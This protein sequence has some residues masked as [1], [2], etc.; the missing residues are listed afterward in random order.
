MRIFFDLLYEVFLVGALVFSSFPAFAQL[1]QVSV[2]DAQLHYLDEGSGEVV[3]FVHGGQEDYRTFEQQVNLLADNFRAISYSRR[4]NYP[5]TNIYETRYDFSASTEATDLA[6]LVS[7]LEIGPVH[8][9]GHSYWSI[10]R[11]DFRY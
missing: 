9:V 3:V 2:N 1:K 5:N 4:Y 11:D 7:Y 6:A 8:L 10:N